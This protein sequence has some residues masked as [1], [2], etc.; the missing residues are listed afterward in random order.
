MVIV[1]I[2]TTRSGNGQW[3]VDVD[4]SGGFPVVTVQGP[5]GIGIAYVEIRA[6]HS[7]HV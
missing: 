3:I 6:R 1:L 4:A 5:L 7:Y 2:P